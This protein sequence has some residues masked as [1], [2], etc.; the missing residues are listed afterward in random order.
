MIHLKRPQ[1]VS[2]RSSYR[3]SITVGVEHA[4]VFSLF[5]MQRSQRSKTKPQLSAVQAYKLAREGGNRAR[6]WDV[7][8]GL[9]R[10]QECY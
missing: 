8:C 4:F 1:K 7:S 10:A 9:S 3:V 2:G 5:T 6:D